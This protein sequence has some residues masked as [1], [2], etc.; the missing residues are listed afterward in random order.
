VT[1]DNPRS[2]WC[3]HCNAVAGEPC[4]RLRRKHVHRART[5]RHEALAEAYLARH[6]EMRPCVGGWQAGPKPGAE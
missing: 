4:R 2:V 3:P 1:D 6:A 5:R